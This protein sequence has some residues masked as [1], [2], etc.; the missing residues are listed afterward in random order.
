[1]DNDIEFLKLNGVDVDGCM[2]RFCGNK[3]LYFKFV[4][5]FS[6]DTNFEDCKASMD[7]KDYAAA[8]RFAHNLKGVSGNLGLSKLYSDTCVVVEFLR[9]NKNEEAVKAFPQLEQTY[10]IFVEVLSKI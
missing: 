2:E 3:D 4:R 9:A 8:F 1:M 10:K 5:K 6:S 7:K